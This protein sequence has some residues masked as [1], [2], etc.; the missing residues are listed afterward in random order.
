MISEKERIKEW[1]SR[2]YNEVD[3]M[4]LPNTSKQDK[5]DMIKENYK[6]LAVLTKVAT[7]NAYLV[8]I[9]PINQLSNK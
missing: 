8:G 9:P 7:G 2:V 4:K 5:L 6:I 3:T 1:L